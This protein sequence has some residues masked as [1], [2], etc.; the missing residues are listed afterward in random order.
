MS[1]QYQSLAGPAG[2]S[3]LSRNSTAPAPSHSVCKTGV[4]HACTTIV[5]LRRHDRQIH[6]W[7]S[8]RAT[9]LTM[10]SCWPTLSMSMNRLGRSWRGKSHAAMSSATEARVR[11]TALSTG[12]EAPLWGACSYMQSSDSCDTS[13]LG[14]NILHYT[15]QRTVL[16]DPDRDEAKPKPPGKPMM[17]PE[18]L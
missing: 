1:H 4:R 17:S 11:V 13:A 15:I 9:S 16:A 8:C 5:Y 10:N 7:S 18:P 6:T 14:L 2:N 12:R 3:K